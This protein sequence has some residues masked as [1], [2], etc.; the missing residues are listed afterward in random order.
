MRFTTVK[1]QQASSELEYHEREMGSRLEDD[2][3]VN[4]RPYKFI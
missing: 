2:Y 4:E 3:I 1:D